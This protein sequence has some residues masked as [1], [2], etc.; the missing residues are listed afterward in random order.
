MSVMEFNFRSQTLNYDTAMNIIIPNTKPKSTGY[1]V[2][3]LL[4][5]LSQNNTSW[6]RK[7][8]IERYVE[9]T[10]IAVVMPDGF[11]S[12]YTNMQSGHRYWDYIS[13]EIPQ[14]VY[15]TF[16]FSKRRED[17]FICGLS[18]GGYGSIKLALSFPESFGC[19]GSLSGCLD[20][21]AHIPE[22]DAPL[23]SELKN[24]FINEEYIAHSDDN[25]MF[26]LENTKD[27]TSL[28][29]LYLACGT[30]DYCMGDNKRFYESI[31]KKGF[32]DIEFEENPGNHNWTFWDEHI[33]HF[34]KRIDE[35]IEF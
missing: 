25:L 27:L 8:N 11:R 17:N 10:D 2:L 31:T 12:F 22:P 14:L 28:P 7:S 9:N 16:N 30:E 15:N 35:K 24:I 13:E 21:A 18:M 32:S 6:C 23:Y 3:W 1:R 33:K 34:L 20:I 29:K 19:A 4:H 26:K 5:G